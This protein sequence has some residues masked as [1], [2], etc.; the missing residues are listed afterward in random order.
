MG[1]KIVLIVDDSKLAQM[2]TQKIFK[3][4]F[5]EWKVIVAKNGDE[6]ILLAEKN[7]ITLALID[8]NMPGMNGLDM[9]ALLMD[10]HPEM[11]INLVTANIQ[12]KMRSRAEAMGVGFIT[13]PISE[14]KLSQV[15]TG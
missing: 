9:A 10:K 7:P 5:P 3:Q 6:G 11:A 15:L 1:Q 2:M 4:T 13:K 8:Y 12:E 14:Q